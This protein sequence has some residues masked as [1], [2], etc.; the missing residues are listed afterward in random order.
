MALCFFSLVRGSARLSRVWFRVVS[1]FLESAERIV[2]LMTKAHST[3]ME[4][5][6]KKSAA[7][8][9]EDMCKFYVQMGKPEVGGVVNIYF[10]FIVYTTVKC[11]HN[12]C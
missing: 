8:C 1:L 5:D 11:V 7:K 2:K 4:L 9:L 12:D 10:A 6:L 3:L